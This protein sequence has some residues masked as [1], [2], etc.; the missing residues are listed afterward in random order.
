MRRVLLLACI[1][2]AVGAG[3]AGA[4]R[5]VAFCKGGDLTGRFAVIPGSAGAGNIVYRLTLRN[6]SHA[7]CAVSGLPAVRLLAAN[8]DPLP[9]KVIAAGPKILAV[10]V[11]LAPGTSATATARFSP[12]V[13]GP[14][15][16]TANG[17][18]ERIAAKLRVTAKGGGTTTVR[19][20]PPTPVCEHGQLQFS[21]YTGG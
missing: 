3:T 6:R 5:S 19:I 16:P 9:T 14:G 21:R 8:G 2:A 17:R 11:R 7:T 10:L 15:E 20:A 4:H 18:C 12:D 1:A 13:P